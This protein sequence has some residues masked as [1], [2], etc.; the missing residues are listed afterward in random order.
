MNLVLVG[1]G[2]WGKNFK[3]ILENSSFSFSLKYIVDPNLKNIG[4]I[5]NDE[6]ILPAKVK[7]YEEFKDKIYSKI[8]GNVDK[9]ILINKQNFC[10]PSNNVSRKILNNLRE[11]ENDSEIKS[12]YL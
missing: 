11:L 9:K 5:P 12:T 7:S 6:F 2:Y 4:F 3:R 1:L 8:M 10:H